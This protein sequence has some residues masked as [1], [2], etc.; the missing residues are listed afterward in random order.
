MLKLVLGKWGLELLFSTL[1][2]LHWSLVAT[3]LHV[4]SIPSVCLWF[5]ATLCS[6][7][8]AASEDTSPVSR[9]DNCPDQADNE[10]RLTRRSGG[11]PEHG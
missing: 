6:Q 11:A 7:D 4:N 5:S 1:E 10:L 3:I 9:H 8:A 2:C